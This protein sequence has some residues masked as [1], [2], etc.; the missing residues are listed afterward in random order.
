MFQSLEPAIVWQ[1]CLNWFENLIIIKT[2]KCSVNQLFIESLIV[3]ALIFSEINHFFPVSSFVSTTEQAHSSP[4]KKKKEKKE[5]PHCPFIPANNTEHKAREHF[6]W[7]T[8]YLG[9]KAKCVQLPVLSNQSH[10]WTRKREK[11]TFRAETVRSVKHWLTPVSLQKLN[12]KHDWTEWLCVSEG[13]SFLARSSI[14]QTVKGADPLILYQTSGAVTAPCIL[15]A[16]LSFSL[17]WICASSWFRED[18]GFE[19]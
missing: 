6:N 1:F 7:V 11:I 13:S 19:I 12:F 5:V 2:D 9:N 10:F 17:D 8:S 3:W 15:M 4:A 18:S 16:L 14:Q